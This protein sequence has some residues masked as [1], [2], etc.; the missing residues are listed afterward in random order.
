MELVGAPAFA[1]PVTAAHVMGKLRA[2]R[3][4]DSLMLK[5]PPA[6]LTESERDRCIRC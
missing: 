5:K 1:A 2:T 3:D 6:N 4:L